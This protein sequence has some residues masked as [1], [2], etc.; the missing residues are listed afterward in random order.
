[1][2]K[3][4]I[5][6][7]TIFVFFA[8]GGVILFATFKGSNDISDVKIVIWGEENRTTFD[9]FL[10][11]FTKDTKRQ[12]DVSYTQIEGGNFLNQVVEALA[13]GVGP[14]MVILSSKDLVS[15]GNKILPIP[16]EVISERNFRDTFIEGGEIFLTKEGILALPISVDP[17]VMYWNRDILQSA[18][19]ASPPQYWTEMFT[20][21]D[22]ITEKD[23]ALNLKKSAVAL[24]E[25]Q[26][27][28]NAKEIIFSLIAQ[29]GS[30]IVERSGGDRTLRV[31]LG[32]VVGASSPVE[33]A[34]RFY[35]EFSNPTK[36]SYSWNRSLPN[37]QDAFIAG[38]LAIYF[39][40]ASE[41]Y[42]IRKKNPNL[43]FDVST[44]PQLSGSE[45][46]L[47]GGEIKGLAV[48]KRSLNP[49][50][51][52]TIAMNLVSEGSIDIFSGI[53]KLPPVRRSLL[54]KAPGLAFEDLFYKSALITKSFLDPDDIETNTI[55]K[56]M[57]DRI[58]SGR[59][60]VSESVRR[61]R[62]ELG[63]LL[64]DKQ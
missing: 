6:L 4:Q 64:V 37:S 22:K 5:I 2:K 31:A 63:A 44:L 42:E 59:S 8:A 26:N 17:L 25:F 11:E 9:N 14:D 3:F 23:E 48:L 33:S 47:T 45:K 49:S 30:P 56:N 32:D 51:A 1:M 12:F 43:N 7:M 29:A 53:N 46:K 19:L 36:T 58:V 24:G 41:L 54:S 27:I 52:I 60:G 38:D 21:A 15:F 18:G 40:F 62:V 10:A 20:L 13:S 50:V 16:Y 35:T 39:G 55:F 57:I 61:A 34:L 28:K